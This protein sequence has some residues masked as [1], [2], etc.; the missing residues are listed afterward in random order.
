[1][2]SAAVAP[3]LSFTRVARIAAPPAG[4]Q[5]QAPSRVIGIAPPRYALAGDPEL[6]GDAARTGGRVSVAVAIA[7]HGGV[8]YRVT[9]IS[10]DGK[11]QI[12]LLNALPNGW[13]DASKRI[14]GLWFVAATSPPLLSNLSYRVHA[15]PA[16]ALRDSDAFARLPVRLDGKPVGV[17]PVFLSRGEHLVESAER[18]LEIE[19]LTVDPVTLPKTGSFGL[20]WKRR[21]PTQL[22][23]SVKNASRPFLLVFGESYHPEWQA[24]LDGKTLT[25]VA[26]N[27]VANGWLIPRLPAAHSDIVLA[28]TA[29]RKYNAAAAV[30][31]VSLVI[32]LA[33]ALVPRRLRRAARAP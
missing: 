24:T 9:P 11:F 13:N 16:L 4:E 29:Q 8:V 33:L 20:S 18:K 32:L 2:I 1:V 22:E 28:F 5:T 14:V 30:S 25:H 10:W 21:S 27:G 19:R 23:V 15:L 26:V 31:L 12:G 3:D 6:Q 17:T 7:E